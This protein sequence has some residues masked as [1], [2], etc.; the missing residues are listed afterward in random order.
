MK[1][2]ISDVDNCI[3]DDG[4]RVH[5]IK[6]HPS[7]IQFAKWHLYHLACVDDKADFDPRMGD[8]EYETHYL[9]GM[10]EA[11]RQYRLAWFIK[12]GKTPGVRNLHMRGNEDFRRNVEV[13]HDMIV[14]LINSWAFDV[15]DVI[16]C[17]DDRREVVQMYNELGLPGVHRAIRD[18]EFIYHATGP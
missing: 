18:E 15:E 17:F 10:P 7:G 13:K 16:A 1:I 2:I 6:D 8:P 14:N 11:Y 12:H 4:H 3:S 9:T 5:L